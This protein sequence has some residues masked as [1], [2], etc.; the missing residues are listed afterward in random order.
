MLEDETL[1]DYVLTY[2]GAS[3]TLRRKVDIK[4]DMSVIAGPSFGITLWGEAFIEKKWIPIIRKVIIK[5]N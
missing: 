5:Y 3:E 4:Y 2:Y 1:R